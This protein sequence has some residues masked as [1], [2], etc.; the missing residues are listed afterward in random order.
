MEK[1][2]CLRKK[3][4]NSYVKIQGPVGGSL[5]KVPK[6]KEMIHRVWFPRRQVEALLALQV[7]G[8]AAS[9]SGERGGV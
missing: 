1:D 8:K 9:V 6:G 3:N 2:F 5:S 4:A 7:V